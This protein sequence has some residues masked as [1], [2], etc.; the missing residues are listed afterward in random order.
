MRCKGFA[1]SLLTILRTSSQRLLLSKYGNDDYF[2]QKYLWE[3][4]SRCLVTLCKYEDNG[5]QS[6]GGMTVSSAHDHAQTF[7]RHGAVQIFAKVNRFV[8]ENEGIGGLVS[9]NVSLAI[10]SMQATRVLAINDEIVQAFVAAG[11]LSILQNALKL[12]HDSPLLVASAMGVIRN[13]C[14][15]DEI[16]STLT[17]NGTLQ[18]ILVCMR[19]YVSVAIIQEHG[20]GALAAMALRKAE[21]A[22]AIAS[23]GGVNDIILAMKAHE[24]NILVQRQGALACRNIISRS[25]HLRDLF[26]ELDAENVL[27]KAG[28]YQGS[29]DEAYAAL[30]DIGCQ[31]EMIKF[32]GN[33]KQVKL[34]MFGDVKPSFNPSFE[35]SND[36]IDRVESRAKYAP[37]LMNP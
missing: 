23:L 24:K 33:G 31:V 37:K 5:K 3:A 22:Q 28:K 30:R 13:M 10:I 6:V 27:R 21:N 25:N 1:E 4:A 14:G 15:N 11:T 36:L 35:A 16:K 32:D 29:V 12:Y 8:Q 18:E 26:L 19:Q 17:G 20:C 34:E 2:Q 7:F 9:E